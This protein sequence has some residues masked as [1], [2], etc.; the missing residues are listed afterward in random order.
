MQFEAVQPYHASGGGLP[1]IPSRDQ[2]CRIKTSGMQNERNFWEVVMTSPDMSAEQRL[3]AYA[4]KR[5]AKDECQI[6][7]TSWRYDPCGYAGRDLWADMPSLRDYITEALTDGGMSYVLLMLGGDGNEYSADGWTYGYDNLRANFKR[8]YSAL[9]GTSSEGPDLTP[10][11]VWCPGFDGVVPGWQPWQKVSD[12]LTFA[13]GIVGPEGVLALELSA[14]YWCWSGEHND[15]AEPAGQ[16]LDV[17]LYEFPY[18]FGPTTARVPDNFCNQS[19]DVRAP[20]DQVWQISKRL[21][22]SLW[23]RPSEMPSCDDPGNAP[24]LPGTP[25][26]RIA[27]NAFEGLTYPMVRGWMTP[28]ALARYRDYLKQIG[29]KDV[30]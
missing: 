29:W 26:G 8:I 30:G 27:V 15:Y 3:A 20:F 25:R 19:N 7:A 18:P 5:A 6:L 9:K 14:G 12:W 1:P 16:C 28:T 22:G 4:D 23:R 24:D 17:V 21:L 11:I 10:Y 2:M 13:R